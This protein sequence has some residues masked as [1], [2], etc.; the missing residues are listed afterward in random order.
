LACD[1]PPTGG[2]GCAA[3]VMAPKGLTSS[4]QR[5]L[6]TGQEDRRRLPRASCRAALI[7]SGD[8][9]RGDLLDD[10]AML[11]KPAGRDRR[12]CSS[13]WRYE[14]SARRCPAAA[15]KPG[16]TR[17]TPLLRPAGARSRAR[18]TAPRRCDRR[19]C[20]ADYRGVLLDTTRDKRPRD[21]S[22][23]A[24]DRVRIRS[25]P[26][27]SQSRAERENGKADQQPPFAATSP[28]DARNLPP[29]TP[30]IARRTLSPA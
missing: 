13:A 6:P 27:P 23:Y 15:M 22:C 24:W 5:G 26:P 21:K 14:A 9:F 25:L 16:R 30:T 10:L 2:S 11:R 20:S 3:R 12:D 28:A 4:P 8:E 1:A 18:S 29:P 7:A 19:H 17:E